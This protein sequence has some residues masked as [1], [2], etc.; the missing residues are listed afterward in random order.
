MTKQIPQGLIQW[1]LDYQTARSWGNTRLALSL[2][3]GIDKAIKTGGFNRDVVYQAAQ[4][5]LTA[6]HAARR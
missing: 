5:Q 1:V 2:K 3:R 6:D 4:V